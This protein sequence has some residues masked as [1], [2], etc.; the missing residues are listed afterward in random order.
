MTPSSVIDWDPDLPLR[1]PMFRQFAPLWQR[2]G[3][4]A[5]WPGVALLTR[6]AR[7]RG[8]ANCQGMTLSFVEPESGPL[9]F[10][11]R[12]EPRTY[13][14]GE[15]QT[16][17][18]NW[19]DALNALA[20][21]TFSRCKAAVN[22]RHYSNIEMQYRLNPGDAS[23]DRLRDALTLADESGVLVACSDA[24]LVR[25]LQEFRWKELF[26][27]RRQEVEAGMEFFLLGHGLMEKALSPF[28][29]FTGHGLVFPVQ[30]GFHRLPLEQRIAALDRRA[31][32][33]VE[34]A[35][36]ATLRAALHPLPLLGV[37][38]WWEPNRQESFYDNTD[39]FRP[40]RARPGAAPV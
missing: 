21:L 28:I 29:G 16:R 20:W 32:E 1:S 7:E 15:V 36:A 30:R 23:R 10:E 27:R 37:P 14:T 24:G 6:W 25:L 4:S 11:R 26:W 2:S 18:H 39:Y 33:L 40:G 34:R 31:A 35:A 5:G 13:L 38:G 22:G 17:P 3:G 8:V 19:H 12:Y 9:P